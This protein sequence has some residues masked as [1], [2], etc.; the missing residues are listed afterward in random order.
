MKDRKIF[1]FDVET[2]GLDPKKQ[3]IIQLAYIIEINGE[4]KEQGSF[5][6]QP[7]NYDTIEKSALGVNKITVE[8]LKTFKTPQQAY[9]ELKN[10][11][12]KYVDPYN[13]KDKFS[14]AGYNVRFDVDFLKEFFFKNGDKYYGALFDYHVLDVFTLAYVLEFKGHLN[15]DSFKLINVAK[16]FDIDFVAHDALADI[17][18]TREVFYKMLEYVK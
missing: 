12:L 11:L 3:D 17:E 5:R 8:E 13:K 9:R 4:I 1:F 7:F 6:C 10:V 15:L 14:P 2:T 18:T 16:S